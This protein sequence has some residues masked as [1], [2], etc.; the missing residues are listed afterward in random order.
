H[1]AELVVL[2][3]ME[4]RR[5]IA[6]NAPRVGGPARRSDN[7]RALGMDLAAIVVPDTAF[8]RLL[9][10]FKDSNGGAQIRA[11]KPVI[12]PCLRDVAVGVSAGLPVPVIGVAEA[13]EVVLCRHTDRYARRGI[14]L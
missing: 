11:V 6:E 14:R 4:L 2:T 1:V 5:T 7:D 13:E 9:C 3:V 8:K 12:D 10:A